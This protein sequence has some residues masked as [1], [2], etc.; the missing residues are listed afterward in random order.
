MIIEITYYNTMFVG[1]KILG[2]YKRC[3]I[4]ALWST[5][6]LTL[7]YASFAINLMFIQSISWWHF[8][9]CLHR[10]PSAARCFGQTVS[11]ASSWLNNPLAK[12]SSFSDRT[13]VWGTFSCRRWD[14]TSFSQE[15]KVKNS[16]P[17]G[18]LADTSH[19]ASEYDTNEHD[20]WNMIIKVIEHTQTLLEMPL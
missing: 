20:N 18:Y 12:I 6:P 17:P 16:F 15:N 13:H 7:I 11:S 9:F 19:F 3:V 8:T 4:T 14:F 5:W 10:V 1:K 2:L